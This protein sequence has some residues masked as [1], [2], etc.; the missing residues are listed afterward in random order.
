MTVSTE[1]SEERGTGGLDPY[2]PNHS[3][4]DVKSLYDACKSGDTEKIFKLHAKCPELLSQNSNQYLLGIVESG[5]IDCYI[6]IESLL[7]KGKGEEERQQYIG[8]IRDTDNESVLHKAC[9]SGSKDMYAY[10]STTY[11]NLVADKNYLLEIARSKSDLYDIIEKEY[12][13]NKK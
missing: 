5:N 2:A 1:R 11:P 8:S 12:E 9:R 13:I 4:S 3:L 7:L 10:I 6:A